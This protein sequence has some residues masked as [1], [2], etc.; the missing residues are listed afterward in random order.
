MIDAEIVLNE[1]HEMENTDNQAILDNIGFPILVSDFFAVNP[2][3]LEVLGPF[4][5]VGMG[6]FEICAGEQFEFYASGSGR[7]TTE[8]NPMTI[9]QVQE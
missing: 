4:D 8:L 6:S 2:G 9:L 3:D 5:P 1:E 7:S